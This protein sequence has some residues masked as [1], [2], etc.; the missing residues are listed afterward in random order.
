MTESVSK[1]LVGWNDRPNPMKF[2]QG[3]WIGRWINKTVRFLDL[4][5]P[6]VTNI[7]ST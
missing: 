7:E 4:R 1:N 3:G 6:T 2:N 5:K